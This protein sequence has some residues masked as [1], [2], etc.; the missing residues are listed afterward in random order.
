MDG[1]LYRPTQKKYFSARRDEPRIQMNDNAK[2]ERE[3]RDV[4]RC[5]MLLMITDLYDHLHQRLDFQGDSTLG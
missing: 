5:M 3:E 2:R 1:C 4:P